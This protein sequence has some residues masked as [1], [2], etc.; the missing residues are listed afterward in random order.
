MICPLNFLCAFID[1]KIKK[2]TNKN[3]A[4]INCVG[5]T[6]TPRTPAG[7]SGGNNIPMHEVVSRP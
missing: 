1:F 3:N 5:I 6:F 4:S 2:R 7:E